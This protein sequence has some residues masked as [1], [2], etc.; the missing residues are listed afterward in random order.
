VSVYAI[1][2]HMTLLKE[3]KEK[4]EEIHQDSRVSP[5]TATPQKKRKKKTTIIVT[6]RR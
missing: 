4:E 2:L 6:P 3:L 1:P 5:S